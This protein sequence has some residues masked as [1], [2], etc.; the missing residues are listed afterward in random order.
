MTFNNKKIAFFLGLAVLF[1]TFTGVFMMNSQAANVRTENGEIKVFLGSTDDLNF[2]EA[3]AYA[4]EQDSVLEQFSSEMPEETGKVLISFD[5]FLT[6][7]EVRNTI[8]NES[9]VTA[10]YLWVPNKTGRAMVIVDGGDIQTSI[11]NWIASLDLGGREDSEYKRD[12]LDLKENYGIF[13]VEAEDQYKEISLLTKTPS[14][15]QVDVFYNEYAEKL[16]AD[17]GYDISYI[18]IPEKP[19]GT[20]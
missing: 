15:K 10:V 19:D 11:D 5:K 12:M 2:F 1:M 7:E 9:A 16:S 14:V 4:K 8:P 17:T 20:D 13:A 18:A 3:K 6:L